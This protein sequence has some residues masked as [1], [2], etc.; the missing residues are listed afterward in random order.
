MSKARKHSGD[1]TPEE[2]KKSAKNL[3]RAECQGKH[4]FP[5][6]DAWLKQRKIA[7]GGGRGRRK[8]VVYKCRFCGFWHSGTP[9]GDRNGKPKPR[10]P[11]CPK[12]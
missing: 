7:K 3:F 1:L 10:P 8:V 6:K 9:K 11:R 12:V 2:R 5:S 4:K